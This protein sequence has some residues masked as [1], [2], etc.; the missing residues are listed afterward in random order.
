MQLSDGWN[1]SQLGDG[2]GD[3]FGL[4]EC[5]GCGFGVCE[6]V[7]DGDGLGEEWGA[8]DEPVTVVCVGTTT[9]VTVRG[10]PLR[11]ISRTITVGSGSGCSGWQS[12]G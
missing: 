11:G 1:R 7:G 6:A 3:G 5:D 12:F 9:N 2:L 8:L 10:F 4:G